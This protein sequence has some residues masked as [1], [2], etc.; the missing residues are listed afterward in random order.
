MVSKMREEEAPPSAAAAAAEPPK[1]GGERLVCSRAVHIGCCV[2]STMVG[3]ECGPAASPCRRVGDC[4]LPL[5]RYGI[6]YPTIFQYLRGLG[7]RPQLMMGAASAGFSLA[8]V[9]T[10]IPLGAVADRYGAKV[11]CVVF[12][13]IAALG[14]LYY[15]AAR[16]PVDV[17]VSR[18]VVG[19]GSSVSSVLC[20]VVGTAT[21][22][23]EARKIRDKRLAVFNATALLAILAGP[24]LSACF[25]LVREDGDDEDKGGFAFTRYRAPGLVMCFLMT[26]CSL[27]ALVALPNRPLV[28]RVQPSEDEDAADG[29]DAASGREL[30]GTLVA[31]RGFSVLFVAFVGGAMIAALDT[32][33]PIVAHDDFALNPT[34]IALLLAFFACTGVLGMAA[35]EWYRRGRD[36][37]HV[38]VRV[39]RLGV[40][41][42]VAGGV[43]C[44]FFFSAFAHKADH[45]DLY[46]A[47][48]A[49][50]TG[51]LVVGGT[52][53]TTTPNLQLLAAAANMKRH[54]GFYSGT[55]AVALSFGRTVGGFCAGLLLS[56]NHS[57]SHW[58]IFLFVSTLTALGLAVFTCFPPKSREDGVKRSSDDLA[59]PL[60]SSSEAQSP[61]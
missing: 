58:P 14:N 24:G 17:V 45:R 49:L 27:W 4:I 43:L 44:L 50:A 36:T 1:A 34:L 5:H 59:A 31:R 26:A 30:Y 37:R 47:P 48:A 32:G 41:F 42:Q 8:R 9:V 11:P 16:R 19:V 53:A 6:I 28:P 60:L 33:F 18:A 57:R 35:S 56:V 38:R 22:D 25:A 23:P 2:S 61:R 12:F 52:M 51:C 55:R 15:F 13:L 7:P 39:V 21:D 40:A 10:F 3:I 54:A 29:D 46:L 20:S